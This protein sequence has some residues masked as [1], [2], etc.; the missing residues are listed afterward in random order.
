ME[1]VDSGARSISNGLTIEPFASKQGDRLKTAVSACRVRQP[2][3]QRPAA[4]AASGAGELMA[5]LA[6]H[7]RG[8]DGAALL[9]R[10][11]RDGGPLHARRAGM[12]ASSQTTASWVAELRPGGAAHWVTATAAPCTS[13]FKPVRRGRAAG[14]S[15]RNRR[16]GYDPATLWWRHEVLHRLVLAQPGLLYPTLRA[17]RDAIQA[18]WVAAPPALGDAFAVADELRASWTGAAAEVG[19][20]DQRP[21]VV[22]RYW[23]LRNERAGMPRQA[24]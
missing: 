19:S 14:R 3:T 13:L 24:A 9:D 11:R 5:A 16:T 12:A 22:R 4:D 8:P 17:E 1:R 2:Q 23:R 21:A 10:E 15:A 20:G 7:G 18:R 6:D